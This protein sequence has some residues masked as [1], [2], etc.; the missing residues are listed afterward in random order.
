MYNVQLWLVRGGGLLK[1]ICGLLVLREHKVE[2]VYDVRSCTDSN[3]HYT[4]TIVNSI[5]GNKPDCIPQY[6]SA[7]C[8][9]LEATYASTANKVWSCYCDINKYLT[10]KTHP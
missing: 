10:I 3:K 5:C 1:I 7:Q 6:N 4:V 9:Y 2:L 8:Q